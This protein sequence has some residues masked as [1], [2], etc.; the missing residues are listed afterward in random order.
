MSVHEELDGRDLRYFKFVFG[1]AQRWPIEAIVKDLDDPEINS[2]QV[3]YQ[4]LARDGYP[5]CPECGKAPV[6]VTHC[7]QAESR[8]Q[9]PGPGTG[10]GTELPA[11]LPASELFAHTLRGLL[12]SV[13][14][15]EFRHDRSQ[16]GRIVGTDA[17]AGSAYLS[18]SCEINGKIVENFSEEKWD[19]LCARHGQDPA[20]EGFWVEGDG[21]KRAAGA[22]RQPAEPETTLIGV[23]ALAGGDM[24]RLLEILYPG[25]PTE[26]IR[27]AIRK[28]VEGKKKLDKIDGLQAI[29]GQLATL[30]RGQPLDGRPPTGLTAVE[31]DAACH[32]TVLRDEGHSDEE[33]LE[34]LSNHKM[35]DGSKLSMEDV[36]WLGNFRLRY[37][38]N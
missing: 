27:E 34:K 31:H 29:A 5:V 35:A 21:L 3:L 7:A 9:Q 26:E 17:I 36:R 37:T 38:E 11:A 30:V 32:I 20:V 1:R 13:T 28:R 12:A 10:R 18:R 33:I 14:D 22:A 25:A 15:L 8:K 16:D 19:E 4:Q 2:P 23:Y 24:E 6:N